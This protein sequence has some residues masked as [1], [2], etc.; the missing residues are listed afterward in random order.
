VKDYLW[1]VAYQFGA[2]LVP[3]PSAI[4]PS[5]KNKGGVSQAIPQTH[6]NAIPAQAIKD[7]DA[8]KVIGISRQVFFKSVQSM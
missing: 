7:I 5:R 1:S 3:I 6:V 4:K 2:Q 8:E